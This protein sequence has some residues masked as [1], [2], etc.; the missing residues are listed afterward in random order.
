VVD[1]GKTCILST[2][3]LSVFSYFFREDMGMAVDDHGF[4]LA[5]HLMKEWENGML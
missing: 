5:G 2:E 3:D 1:G 4:F